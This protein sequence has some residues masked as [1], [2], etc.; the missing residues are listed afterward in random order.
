[1]YFLTKRERGDERWE[2]DC[3]DCCRCD[4]RDVVTIKFF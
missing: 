2:T 3:F 4:V 1:V